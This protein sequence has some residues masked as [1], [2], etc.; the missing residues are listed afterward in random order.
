MLGATLLAALFAITALI[1]FIMGVVEKRNKF[2][3]IAFACVL[4]CM[5]FGGY[6][7][8][9][10][11]QLTSKMEEAV[12]EVILETMKPREKQTVYESLFGGPEDC[13]DILNSHDKS[14]LKLSRAIW[15]EALVCPAEVAR[16]SQLHEYRPLKESTKYVVV[17]EGSTKPSW[18]QPYNMGDSL[19]ILTEKLDSSGPGKT[20]YV[21]L[22]SNMIY[23]LESQRAVRLKDFEPSR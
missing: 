9:K 19:W 2:F 5:V 15:L 13:V 22:D 14:L 12:N 16:I 18:F 21:S 7:I 10:W 8:Y 20:L 3:N 11:Q 17:P 23:A 6:S 4:G 1:M